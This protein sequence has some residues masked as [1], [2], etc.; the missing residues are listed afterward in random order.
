MKIKFRKNKIGL[1]EMAEFK[2]FEKV[3]GTYEKY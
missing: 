1:Q 3:D 2:P